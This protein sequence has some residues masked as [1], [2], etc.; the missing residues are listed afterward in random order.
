M[1]ADDL[2]GS[3]GGGSQ[4]CN[5][6]RGGVGRDDNIVAD[7]FIQL[8]QQSLLGLHLL[9]SCF[10]DK[11]DVLYDFDIRAAVNAAHDLSLLILGD[12][13]FGDHLGQVLLDLGHTAVDRRLSSGSH[14]D[15]IAILR[16]DLD[17]AGTHSPGA[18][19]A[20]FHHSSNLLV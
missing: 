11:I 19:Y 6:E 1:H 13:L 10:N 4:F 3:L 12:L 20:D 18:K 7:E 15:F 8:C 14:V 2:V 9:E 5:R 16:Q 17:N